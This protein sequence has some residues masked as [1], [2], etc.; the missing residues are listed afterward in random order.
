MPS[1]NKEPKY[2]SVQL[3]LKLKA[4]FKAT[5]KSSQ[6]YAVSGDKYTP[7]GPDSSKFFSY[8]NGKID[9]YFDGLSVGGSVS[10]ANKKAI[11][12]KIYAGAD[13]LG[14]IGVT[15]K[16]HSKDGHTFYFK[17]TEGTAYSTLMWDEA[18]RVL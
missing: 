13:K 17:Q 4:L 3:R 8:S 16:I 9:M 12:S 1:T 10:T 15:H 14:G 7:A 18:N 6:K 2:T 5:V 11:F